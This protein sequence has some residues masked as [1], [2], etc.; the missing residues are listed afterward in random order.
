MITIIGECDLCGK[1]TKN[2]NS[3]ILYKKSIDYCNDCKNKAK[4]IKKEF[5]KQIQ[6]EYLWFERTVE[7]IERNFYKGI[8]EPKNRRYL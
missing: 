2:L 5:K 7:K 6:E 3:I 8:I 4:E 1:K